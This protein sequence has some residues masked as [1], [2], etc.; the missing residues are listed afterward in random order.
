MLHLLIIYLVWPIHKHVNCHPSTGPQGTRLCVHLRPS[1][2]TEPFHAS[3]SSQPRFVVCE[4]INS[5]SWFTLTSNGCSK[6]FVCRV[7]G[8]TRALSHLCGSK[9]TLLRLVP[10]K[11][12]KH[13]AIFCLS[14]S[15][16]P[17]YENQLSASLSLSLASVS[18]SPP[19]L[20]SSVTRLIWV[21]ITT[22]CRSYRREAELGAARVYIGPRLNQVSTR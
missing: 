16:P 15:L 19:S 9:P 5:W 4:L 1:N 12:S 8:P 6:M 13:L 20:C 18:I 22:Q 17:T 2:R 14:F 11:A 3:A 21:Y 7:S 10:P